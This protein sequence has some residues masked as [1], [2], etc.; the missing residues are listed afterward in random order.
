VQTELSV[1]QRSLAALTTEED[2][3]T[4]PRP[5]FSTHG[6]LRSLGRKLGSASEFQV[7]LRLSRHST[8][9]Q[10]QAPILIGWPSSLVRL[11]NCST[12]PATAASVEQDLPTIRIFPAYD[13]QHTT[14]GST[15][16]PRENF[17][18][19]VEGSSSRHRLRVLSTILRFFRDNRFLLMLL[20][21][22]ALLVGHS[23]LWCFTA[24]SRANVP[25]EKTSQ[26][27]PQPIVSR[28]ASCQ[29]EHQKK[30]PRPGNSENPVHNPRENKSDVL[31]EQLQA[32]SRSHDGT[33][34]PTTP[35]S[36]PVATHLLPNALVH[37][38]HTEPAVA[39]LKIRT[40]SAFQSYY[41]KLVDVA[42]PD[43]IILTILPL[44]SGEVSV[45]V[46][47][48]TFELR[49]ATGPLW[50]NEKELFGPGTR[51]FRADRLLTFQKENH[52]VC[53]YIAELAPQVFGNTTRTRISPEDF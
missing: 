14:T 17:S 1:T 23:L 13:E 52:E 30:Y 4:F 45:R 35:T 50:Q 12:Q 33:L 41:V 40:K 26:K 8:D 31:P 25:N 18:N 36:K 16:L 6:P 3:Y 2:M 44:G 9:E 46:P 22:L 38:Y 7:L 21:I 19:I 29:V 34:H 47:L 24:G 20:A 48:G 42:A 28:E 5:I 10:P 27:R 37:R 32:G 11:T 49:Y 53:G 43:R 51:C 39:P 15:G